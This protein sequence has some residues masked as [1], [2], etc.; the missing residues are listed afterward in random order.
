MVNRAISQ[1]SGR[2]VPCYYHTIISNALELK[3]KDLTPPITPLFH[4]LVQHQLIF[5]S[6]RDFK[7][8][9]SVFG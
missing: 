9:I 7:F 3:H 2:K 1:I 5:F 6:V 4:T 8:I